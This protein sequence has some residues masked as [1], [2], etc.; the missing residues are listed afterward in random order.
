[1]EFEAPFSVR[2]VTQD[3]VPVRDIIDSLLAVEAVLNE[4]AAFLPRIIDGLEVEQIQIRV[5]EIAQESPLREL[6]IA[7]LFLTFQQSLEDEVPG[8]ITSA[9]GV[10]IPDRFDTIVTVLVL[11]IVFYGVGAIKDVV[12][13]RGGEGP[14]KKKLEALVEELAN[15][16]GTSPKTI[17]DRL[18]ERYGEKAPWKRLVAAAGRFFKPSKSQDSAPMEVNHRILDQDLIRDVPADYQV[19]K[20]L[21]VD[22]FRS[23]S[24]VKLE[25]HAQDK[26][27]GGKGWAALIPNIVDR[28]VRL[29]LMG[30]VGT[31][32]LW[33]QDAVRG[34]VTVVY[35]RVGSEMLPKA[36]HLHRVCDD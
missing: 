22:P 21:K 20:A 12:I 30:E 6:F 11:V 3:A 23:F 29:K 36:I 27:H 1:M 18:D 26:D 32:D 14:A 10:P 13:G 7:T 16:L 35:E 34:D 31:G 8:A 19:D 15:M 25:L 5:R 24:N 28:R 9:T 17:Q 4:A 33:G 2:Y